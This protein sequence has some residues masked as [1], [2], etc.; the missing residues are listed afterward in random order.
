[1]LLALPPTFGMTFYTNRRY[2]PAAGTAR[3]LNPSR[4][5]HSVTWAAA[6]CMAGSMAPSGIFA[7]SE[8]WLKSKAQIRWSWRHT[9]RP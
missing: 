4:A 2:A 5:G 6:R 7:S 9:S 1:M 8:R 3:S